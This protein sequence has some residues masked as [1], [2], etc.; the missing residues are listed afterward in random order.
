MYLL[1]SW[2]SQHRRCWRCQQWVILRTRQCRRPFVLHMRMLQTRPDLAMMPVW[3]LS[4]KSSYPFIPN[5]KKS[6]R[7]NFQGA[8]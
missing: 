5:L 1:G 8:T 3:I 4:L 7:A 6:L 2:H